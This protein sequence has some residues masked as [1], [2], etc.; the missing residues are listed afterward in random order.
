MG[1]V[2]PQLE[3]IR[4][5]QFFKMLGS[6]GKKGFSILPS[7]SVYSLLCVWNSPADAQRFFSYN[8]T[9]RHLR[10]TAEDNWT[11]FMRCLKSHGRWDGQE[12][13]STCKKN[14]NAG[15]AIAVI[16]RA[17]IRTRHLWRFWRFVPPVSRS[18]H[19]REGLIFSVGIG[20][21]PLVQQAT[22]SLWESEQQM[23]SYAYES[24][25]HRKV[26]KKTRELGWY[27]E[28]L[29]ARFQPYDTLGRWKGVDPLEPYLNT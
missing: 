19:D 20:E 2:P 13:F 26:I 25:H 17:T 28:E 6:G 4:G 23:K 12:P 14:K 21:L 5:L 15:Q 22:V 8:E 9:Y 29:F 1:L 7:L 3:S 27:E 11:V 16:T 18:I 10:S 24:R